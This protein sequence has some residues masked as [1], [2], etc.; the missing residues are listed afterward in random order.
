M[1]IAIQFLV[2]HTHLWPPLLIRWEDFQCS[3]CREITSWRI[4]RV[5]LISTW[6]DIDLWKK[7]EETDDDTNQKTYTTT[8][9][10][11]E[12][13]SNSPT[14]HLKKEN[15][16]THYFIWFDTMYF[17]TMIN[18]REGQVKQTRLSIY[19]STTGI[20]MPCELKIHSGLFMPYVSLYI[21]VT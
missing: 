4:I 17:T 1:K 9:W 8:R 7:Q 20:Q 15:H 11:W 13:R 3:I 14:D 18:N 2:T 16:I 6:S 21:Y 10:W 19:I 5:M 12:N